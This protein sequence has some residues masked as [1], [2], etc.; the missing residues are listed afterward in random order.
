MRML[1]LLLRVPS[2]Q[3]AAADS[4]PAHYFVSRSLKPFNPQ[5]CTLPLAAAEL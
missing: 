1:F 4:D 3:I 5:P 2:N